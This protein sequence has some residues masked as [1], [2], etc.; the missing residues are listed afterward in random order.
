L[1]KVSEQLQQIE[2][3]PIFT[4][5]STESICTDLRLGVKFLSPQ[6]QALKS[7]LVLALAMGILGGFLP[8]ML[9]N[10]RENDAVWR[11]HKCRNEAT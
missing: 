4:I 10:E 11:K 1:F 2:N 7:H 6:V 5:F 9:V 3:I 8:A